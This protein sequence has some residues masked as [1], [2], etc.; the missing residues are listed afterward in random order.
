MKFLIMMSLLVYTNASDIHAK[1]NLL[2][3]KNDLSINKNAVGFIENKG[4]L[5]NTDGQKADEVLFYINLNSLNI[6]FKRDAVVYEFIK[7]VVIE[8]NIQGKRSQDRAVNVSE[9]DLFEDHYRLDMLFKNTKENVQI[10][11]HGKQTD[12]HNYYLSDEWVQNVGLYSQIKY[13]NIYEGIDLVFY[14]GKDG[15]QLKYDFII[16]PNANPDLIKISYDGAE[17]TE[18]NENG[19]LF[20]YT[21]IGKIRELAPFT[22]QELGGAKIEVP[23]F[24]KMKEGE[25]SFGLGSYQSKLPLIIDPSVLVW[26]TYY[27]GSGVTEQGS[28]I[29]TDNSG[30]LFVVGN[31]NGTNFPVTVG[32]YQVNYGGVQDGFMLKF[33][34]NGNRLWATYFGGNRSDNIRSCATDA[35]GNIFVTGSTFSLNLPTMN[36]GGG[37]YFQSVNFASTNNT[38]NLTSYVAKF[39]SNGNL[40]WSTFLGGGLGES[41][42]DVWIDNN[43]DLIV[44]GMSASTDFPVTSGAF[45]T[46]NAGPLTGAGIFGDAY[47][48]KFTNSGVLQWLTFIGGSQDEIGYG[49]ATD[50][51][52]NVYATGWTRSTNFPVSNDAFQPTYGGGTGDAFVVKFS[53]TGNRI[54]GSFYGGTGEERALDCVFDNQH[55]FLAG[56]TSGNLPGPSTGVFQPNNTGGMGDGFVVKIAAN[57]AANQ[58]VWRTFA[59]GS[60]DDGIDEITVDNSRNLLFC[61]FTNSS[62]YPITPN[63]LQPLH[64]GGYDGYVSIIDGTADLI[65]SS[66]FGGTQ[67]DN[68]Y[69]IGVA[70]NGDIYL[71]GFT[72]ST[73]AQGFQ[74]SANAFQSEKSAGQDVFI[75][76]LSQFPPVPIASFSSSPEGGCVPLNIDFTN[77]SESKETCLSSNIYNWTFQGATPTSSNLENPTSISYTNPGTF[78]VTLIVTNISGSDT[79]TKTIEIIQLPS[80]DWS[81]PDTICETSSALDLNTLVSGTSGG[82]FSGTNVTNNSFDPAG[83]SGTYEITYSVGVGDCVSQQSKS[84]YVVKL[85]E[86]ELEFIDEYCPN[87][88]LQAINVTNAENNDIFWYSD[89]ALT[90][91]IFSGNN[92]IPASQTAE[93][94]VVL[95]VAGCFSL[96]TS[97]QITIHEIESIIEAETENAVMPFNLIAF[98]QSVNAESCQWFFNGEEIAYTDGETLLITDAGQYE[99]MLV[100][101][102]TFNCIDTAILSFEVKS[103]KVE[104]NIPN[105]FTPNNDNVNDL[106]Q[107]ELNGIN[108]L[109]G[110]I[111]NRWG[112][113]VYE[114]DGLQAFWDGT[115]NGN[116]APEGVYFYII[117]ANDIFDETH[118]KKGTVTLIRSN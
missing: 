54:W 58:V 75:A 17:K 21:P 106:F 11:G 76:R 55:I 93:Y 22:F 72:L 88:V 85:P 98:N 10:K 25:I 2:S 26:S 62:N 5:L 107:L 66:Y 63:A 86:P 111:Y 28:H 77:T 60:L 96:P 68:T 80:A 50:A 40:I 12:F 82:A 99:L 67:T 42:I 36:P 33:D 104:I 49:V 43:N 37:A 90:N 89:D 94:F 32:A 102:N 74:V 4:Q 52:N 1:A 78:T 92:F 105:V 110:F 115:V 79:L 56:Y 48:G 84:T 16:S 118:E 8:Q 13:S 18:I 19:E 47:V 69:G 29:S 3:K 23:S 101:K 6:Y 31:T 95:S 81:L 30:N 103:D 34:S 15:H 73:T 46:T 112:T 41:G 114:W 38:V 57:A 109:A 70:A 51:N 64:G 53:P 59:G 44:S 91:Q 24:F 116:D 117:Q 113:L 35:Q 61:G 27:G 9:P 39:D 7:P 65:C 71:T 108:S 20:V 97:F 83:L 100:C 87:D 45:Q 14:L